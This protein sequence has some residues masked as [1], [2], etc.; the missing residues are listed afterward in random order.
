MPVLPE[1]EREVLWRHIAL[2][3]REGEI[4]SLN[5]AQLR[6][7]IDASDDWAVANAA[8]FNSALPEEAKSVLTSPEKT[9]LLSYVVRRRDLIKPSAE[10]SDQERENVALEAISKNPGSGFTSLDPADLRAAVDASDT[11]AVENAASF[12]S[13][14]PQ[15]ARGIM[16]TPQKVRILSLV[17]DWRWRVNA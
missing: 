13:A 6:P 8:S 14:I 5:R 3:N 9:L 12:N 15:P 4:D 17:L 10:L 1:E 11:W 2:T 7:V 16:K